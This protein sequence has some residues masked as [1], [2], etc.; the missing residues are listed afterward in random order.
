M[1]SFSNVSK[2]DQMASGVTSVSTLNPS[3]SG[4]KFWIWEPNLNFQ[5]T[6]HP[7]PPEGMFA[8]VL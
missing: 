1:K 6:A 7:G 3:V 4:V 2:V 8:L 5:C